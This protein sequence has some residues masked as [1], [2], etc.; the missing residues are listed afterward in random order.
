M[1]R[2]LI[3]TILSGILGASAFALAGRADTSAAA[4][5]DCDCDCPLRGR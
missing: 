4:D 3:A 2:L 1:K 5:C